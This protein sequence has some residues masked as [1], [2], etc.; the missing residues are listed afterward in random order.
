MMQ[1]LES[2]TL[3]HMTVYFVNSMLFSKI[4]V[5]LARFDVLR[6]GLGKNA[7]AERNGCRTERMG[8]KWGTERIWG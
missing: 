4:I 1:I 5:Y 7:E 3:F 8:L 2:S 6:S